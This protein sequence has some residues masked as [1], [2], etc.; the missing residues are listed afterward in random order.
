M[1]NRMLFTTKGHLRPYLSAAIPK[2]IEPTERNISTS[3]MPQVMSF[4]VFPNSLARSETV[5]ETVKKSKASAGLASVQYTAGCWYLHTIPSP[6]NEC[7]GKEEPL[8][9]VEHSQEANGIGDLS[10]WRLERGESRGDVSSSSHMLVGLASSR[11]VLLVVGGWVCLIHFGRYICLLDSG[12]LA[13]V[14]PEALLRA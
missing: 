11:H 9:S 12:S 14:R 8:L 10:H 13:L 3:V 6:G 4:V 1:M 7:D 2:A 5:S